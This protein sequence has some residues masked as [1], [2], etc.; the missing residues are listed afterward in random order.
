MPTHHVNLRVANSRAAFRLP[1]KHEIRV[2]NPNSGTYFA[3]TKTLFLSVF[4]LQLGF[5]V[6][7]S[8][9]AFRLPPKHEIRVAN[10]NSGTYFATTKTLFLSVFDLQLGFAVANSRATLRLPPKH[11]IR[12]ANPNSGTYFATTKTLFLST[13]S[14]QPD[15]ILLIIIRKRPLSMPS[16]RLFLLITIWSVLLFKDQILHLHLLIIS[17]FTY[18]CFAIPFFFLTANTIP[19]VPPTATTIRVAMPIHNPTKLFSEAVYVV[20]SAE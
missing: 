20:S 15:L 10:P 7:N 19:T 5:A 9:A 2:A 17:A 11:E 8:R 6:A 12:V 4:D 3:T 1:P 13:H 14:L 18:N 16:G